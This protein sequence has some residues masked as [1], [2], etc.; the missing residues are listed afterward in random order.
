MAGQG[1]QIST[2]AGLSGMKWNF[3][4]FNSNLI[5][6]N[7][8]NVTRAIVSNPDLLKEASDEQ[9]NAAKT[10]LK[11]YNPGQRAKRQEKSTAQAYLNTIIGERVAA[12]SHADFD[13][14]QPVPGE[15]ETG[16]ESETG[17][18]EPEVM[19]IAPSDVAVIKPTADGGF[20]VAAQHHEATTGQDATTGKPKTNGNVKPDA[21]GNTTKGERICKEC[22]ISEAETLKKNARYSF[23]KGMCVNCYNK[24]AR[25]KSTGTKDESLTEEQIRGR[26]EFY[27]GQ[28]AKL[29]AAKQTTEGGTTEGVVTNTEAAAS[30]SGAPQ[31]IEDSVEEL[32]E[33]TLT[34]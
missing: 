9:L 15:T 23:C 14:G 30:E 18:S 27:E 24:V 12:G 1:Q 4:G 13:G 22:G 28:L 26:I 32:A 11:S 20:E 5:G 6:G 8:D 7:A 19:T 2:G 21:F 34:K 31:V 16:E 3:A 29:L 17:G 10:L 33:V 25:G